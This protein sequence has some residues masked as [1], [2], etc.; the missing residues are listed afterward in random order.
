MN[1]AKWGFKGRATTDRSS[2]P[3]TWFF[4][5]ERGVDVGYGHGQAL[6]TEA[7]FLR[8]STGEQSP[9]LRFLRGYGWFVKSAT[10][11]AA[12]GIERPGQVFVIY[13]DGGPRGRSFHSSTARG[14]QGVVGPIL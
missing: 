14:K 3:W 9:M 2:A 1:L 8:I 12:Q 6:P 10:S 4:T 13:S 11:G 7:I 5:P